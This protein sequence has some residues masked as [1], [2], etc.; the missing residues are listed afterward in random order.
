MVASGRISEIVGDRAL[1]MDK[2][3]RSIGMVYGAKRSVGVIMKDP[4]TAKVLSAYTDGINAY[5]SQLK[6]K[7]YPLEYKLLD[8]K[9]EPWSPLKTS[10]L[11]MMMTYDLSGHTDDL[12]MS[13][14]L[15]KYGKEV[16]AE[17]FPNYPYRE[18]PIIPI[19]SPIDFKPIASPKPPEEYTAHFV[20]DFIKNKPDPENGSNNWAISATKSASNF[21]ILANDPHL[22]LNLPSIWFQVQLSAPGINVSGVSLPG[23]PAVIIGF[24]EQIA[25]G[26]TNV[27]SDVLDFYKITFKDGIRNEYLHDGKWK[28]TQYKIEEIKV[29][30]KPSVFDTVRYTHH[31]PIVYEN[32]EKAFKSKI[33][34]GYALRWIG[35]FKSNALKTFY[36]LNKAKNYTDYVKALS[37]YTSPAQNFVFADIHKDI[38]LW[39]NG[40]FP[41]KWKEQGKFVLDGANPAHDWKQMLPHSHVPHVRNPSRG[42]VSS[43]NQFS[44]DTLYPYYMDWQY[45]SYERGGRINQKLSTMNGATADSMI[46]LQNDNLN[47]HAQLILPF[48]LEK[49]DITKMDSVDVKVLNYLKNWDYNNDKGSIAA[50]VFDTWWNDFMSKTWRDEFGGPEMRYPSRDV[51]VHLMLNK[52]DA[53]WFDNVKTNQKEQL[54]HLILGSY[55]SSIDTLTKNKGTNMED[56]KWGDHKA[57]QLYHLARIP[58]FG[59]ENIA[60][61]GGK[62]IVNATSER[63]GPSWKM[64]V[65]V[66]P[67]IRGYGIFPGGQSGNPGSYYYDNMVETWSKGE[68]NPILFYGNS[69]NKKEGV[70]KTFTINPQN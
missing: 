44:V 49:I 7:D 22:G 65:E 10:L 64:V 26:V 60:M 34:V 4:E 68:L 36:S 63:H 28:P 51:T 41:H 45:A 14:I 27:G 32:N 19:G 20:K 70:L 30:D 37:Y 2:Y 40:K 52:P 16:V 67:Q 57:T 61:G 59:V 48:M 50:T 46:K 54:I 43:A 56:W 17:L 1:E 25:W 66:G 55:K 31:G 18:D 42:F 6:T 29:R 3:Y 53:S 8:Y 62:G 39:V 33:P 21:P 69:N 23:A 38:A 24:N 58:G 12:V 11:L 5:I 15:A 9:P 13:N 35:H 47:L